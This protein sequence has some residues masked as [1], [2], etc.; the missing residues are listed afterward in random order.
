MV[1]FTVDEVRGAHGLPRTDPQHVRDCTRRSRASRRCPTR[2]WGLPVSSRWRMPVTSASWTPVPTRL[3]VVFTIKS[4]AISMPLP[5]AAGD[6]RR[7]PDDK[8]DFLI[9]L[10]DSPGHVDLQLRGDRGTPWTD[11]ALVVVDCVEGVCVQTET[12]LRQALT[13]RIRLLYSSTG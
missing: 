5:R 12:G 3:R 9:N 7:L 2:L 10:I 6:H 4:T 11:G 13:E 1:N 8:R